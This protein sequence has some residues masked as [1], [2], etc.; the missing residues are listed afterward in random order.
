LKEITN[1]VI[2]QSK[3]NNKSFND[4]L[5]GEMKGKELL[6]KHPMMSSQLGWKMA[7]FR[8]T[9]VFWITLPLRFSETYWNTWAEVY[10][11]PAK[12]EKVEAL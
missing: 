10:R 2:N 6:N 11:Q 12:V 9:A 7:E 4:I 1:S 5:S 8:N 3:E